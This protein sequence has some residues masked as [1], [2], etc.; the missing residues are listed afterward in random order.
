[1]KP[2]TK[3]EIIS[4]IKDIVFSVVFVLF[5]CNFV[6]VNASVPSGS[7]E[8]TIMTNDRIIAN[9][10][11]YIF[12]SPKRDDIVVFQNPNYEEELLKNP[13]FKEKLLVKRLIGMPG[14]TVD[15]KNNCV[16]I[17]G[18]LLDEPY[19]REV[20]YTN[21]ASYKVPENAYFMMGDNRNYSFDARFWKNTFVYKEKI[22][23]KVVFKY[24]PKLEIMTN[25]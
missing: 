2:E 20:M 15:I 6:I 19:L 12:D 5:L 8:S 11:S 1:M 17:N 23:G 22:R 25:K 24:F 9:R 3:K 21:D 7:M 13:K 14:D 18:E 10:L 16:Y 4:W